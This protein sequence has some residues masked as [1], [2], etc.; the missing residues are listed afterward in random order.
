M[1]ELT[2]FN[3][4]IFIGSA[5]NMKATLPLDAR[6]VVPVWDAETVNQLSVDWLYNGIQI[7]CESDQKY[8]VLV[9]KNAANAFDCTWKEVG[10]DISELITGVTDNIIVFGPGNKGTKDSGKSIETSIT[11]SDSKLPTSKAVSDLVNSKLSNVYKIQGSLSVDQL[12]LLTLNQSYIGYVYNVTDSGTLTK[13]SVQVNSGDNVVVI[14]ESEES[15]N[16][17]FDKLAAN[18]DLSNYLTKD[19]LTWRTF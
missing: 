8:R 11:N 2:Y 15:E 6:T 19:K 12:N 14:K 17:I 10:G 1:A 4:G 5:F 13:G 7:Y 18:V 16:Y 9:N 3:K